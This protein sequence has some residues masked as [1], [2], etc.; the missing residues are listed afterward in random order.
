MKSDKTESVS[1]LQSLAIKAIST[2]PFNNGSTNQT[3]QN[4]KAK[5]NRTEHKDL[6]FLKIQKM[7]NNKNSKKATI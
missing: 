1:N 4:V 3:G 7:N 6:T 5:K 2:K